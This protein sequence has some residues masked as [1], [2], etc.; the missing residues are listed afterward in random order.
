EKGI[1]SEEEAVIEKG[2]ADNV[3][4]FPDDVR[5]LLPKLKD[6][7]FDRI[8]VLFPDPWPKKRHAERRFICKENLDIFA[9]L[10]KD[11]GKLR[12]A[13]DDVKYINWALMHTTVHS[14]FK[15]TAQKA[16]DWLMRPDD[17]AETRY[18]AKAILQGRKPVYLDF[19]R[20][21]QK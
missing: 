4:I 9:R 16:D 12:I 7:S 21:P 14:D 2:R 6:A 19:I 10:L 5:K 13:S 8:F 3:R 17:G 11:G 20:L 15:W 1:Q 18:E